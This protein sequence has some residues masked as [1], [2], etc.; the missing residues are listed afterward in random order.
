[1]FEGEEFCAPEGYDEILSSI[2]NDYM[3]LPPKEK[4][5]KSHY[6]KVYFK[7]ELDSV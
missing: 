7:P 3:T 5:V 1:M 6:Y 2:Y 4:R